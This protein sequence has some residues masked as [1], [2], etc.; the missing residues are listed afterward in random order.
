LGKQKQA[1]QLEADANN[2]SINTYVG[3]NRVAAKA[4]PKTYNNRNWDL[5]DAKAEDDRVIEKIDLKTL[6]DSLK[7]KSREQI[8]AIVK[9]KGSE[10]AAIQKEIQKVSAKREVYINEEKAKKIKA[11]NNTQTLEGEVE[12]MIREQAKRFNMKI[13]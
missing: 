4:S 9:Q 2:A 12:K 11:N 10:R 3:V 1:M 7:N 13:E 5:V 6:P 8:D